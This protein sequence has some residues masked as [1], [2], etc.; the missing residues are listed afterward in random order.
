M[1]IGLAETLRQQSYG[2][3][4]FSAVSASLRNT[5]FLVFLCDLAPLREIPTYLLAAKDRV[6]NSVATQLKELL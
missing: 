4:I 5:P 2:I 6:G 1:V 3:S